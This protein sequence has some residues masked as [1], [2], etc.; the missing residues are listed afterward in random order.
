MQ[1]S[2]F[3][4]ES[5][6]MIRKIQIAINLFWYSVLISS[7]SSVCTVVFLIPYLDNVCEYREVVENFEKTKT[8][9]NRFISD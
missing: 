9:V 8:F 3:N 5:S 1:L 4:T 7:I 6:K 2:V